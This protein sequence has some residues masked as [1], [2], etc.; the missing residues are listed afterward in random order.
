AE[1]TE[2]TTTQKELGSPALKLQNVLSKEGSN[3]RQR[4]SGVSDWG[5]V[6]VLGDSRMVAC[7]IVRQS[8]KV[9]AWRTLHAGGFTL[10]YLYGYKQIYWCAKSGDLAFVVR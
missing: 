1:T 6:R 4:L 7:Q 2:T 8:F 9:A 10:K 3:I 5:N